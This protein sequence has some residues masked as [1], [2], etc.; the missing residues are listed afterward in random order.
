MYKISKQ[1]MD[2][3]T[4]AI[5][6]WKRIIDRTGY[7]YSSQNCP[8][9]Q[10]NGRC[11]ICIVKKDSEMSGCKNT[12]YQQWTEHHDA[13]H[14]SYWKQAKVNNCDRCT[15][16]AQAEHDYLVDLKANCET[17]FMRSIVEPIIR[18]IHNIIYL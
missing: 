11:N 18:F 6:K 15:E 14:C 12:P 17:N 1:Q 5:V 2:A 16:F 10:L 3:L 8:L 13:S 4:R 7:D 9:C